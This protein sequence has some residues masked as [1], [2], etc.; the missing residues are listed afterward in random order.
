MGVGCGGFNLNRIISNKPYEGIGKIFKDNI[1]GEGKYH[2]RPTDLL[3]TDI[4][5][6]NPLGFLASGGERGGS[7]ISQISAAA[8]TGQQSYGRLFS[9]IPK[10]FGF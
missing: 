4:A 10:R 6:S 9:K 8:G 1:V 2:T 5:S 3:S 7:V